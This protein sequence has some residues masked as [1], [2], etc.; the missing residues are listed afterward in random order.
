MPDSREDIRQQLFKLS[1][2][3]QF[4]LATVVAENVGYVLVAENEKR[5]PEIIWI[6]G[7][8]YKLIAEDIT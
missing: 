1:C 8:R 2:D 7:E 4:W 3:D 5:N 6:D